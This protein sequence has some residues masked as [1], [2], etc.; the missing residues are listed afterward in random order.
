[1]ADRPTHIGA[2]RDVETIQQII[3]EP[4]DVYGDSMMPIYGPRLGPEVI[5]ELAAHFGRAKVAASRT[6]APVNPPEVIARPSC[7]CGERRVGSAACPS[8]RP[9]LSGADRRP[10]RRLVRWPLV[11]HVDG[12]YD[13]ERRAI[14]DWHVENG[15]G[16]VHPAGTRR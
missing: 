11:E 3:T 16:G 10:E 13:V 9:G 1:V 5:A 8:G 4:N 14:P 15:W 2:R 12:V 7:W 6:A